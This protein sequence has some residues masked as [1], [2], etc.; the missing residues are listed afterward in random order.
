MLCVSTCT[1]FIGGI[2]QSHDRV[3]TFDGG[4]RWA[5]ELTNGSRE[6]EGLIVDVGRLAGLRVIQ[7]GDQI[8]FPLVRLIPELPGAM[9]ISGGC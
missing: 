3:S 9:L 1:S 5:H 2:P 7:D 6:G 4:A 8:P